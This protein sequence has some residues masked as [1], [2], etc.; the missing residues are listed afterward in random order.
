[1][2]EI[3]QKPTGAVAAL[4]QMMFRVARFSFTNWS[5]SKNHS[6]MPSTFSPGTTPGSQQVHGG[7]HGFGAV[8]P[9]LQRPGAHSPSAFPAASL[10]CV[11]QPLAVYHGLRT[12]TAM[13]SQLPVIGV[14][15]C[16]SEVMNTPVT[17]A[18]LT[19]RRIFSRPRRRR[20]GPFQ[21]TSPGVCFPVFSSILTSPPYRLTKCRQALQL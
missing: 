12:L 2:E 18:A 14:P 9:R 13:C 8:L 6:A 5:T 7:L 10:K 17:V 15:S 3:W 11:L 4:Y 19:F 16:L 21:A 20:P 1:M